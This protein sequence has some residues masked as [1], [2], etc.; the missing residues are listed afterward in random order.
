MEWMTDLVPTLPQA[1]WATFSSMV[2]ENRCSKEAEGPC[3]LGIKEGSPGE[4]CGRYFGILTVQDVRHCQDHAQEKDTP[5]QRQPD[6]RGTGL[7]EGIVGIMRLQ[8]RVNP[9]LVQEIVNDGS[10]GTV[11]IPNSGDH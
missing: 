6:R 7:C 3:R 1:I 8:R 11:G 4:I 10:K 5:L 2:M 9:G